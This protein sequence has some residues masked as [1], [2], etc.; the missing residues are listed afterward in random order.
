MKTK[1]TLINRR[2][3]FTLVEV[4][5]MIVIIA[6][7][8]LFYL[9]TVT[10]HSHVPARRINCMN[11]LKQIGTA[12]RLWA[13]DNG[14]VWPSQQTVASHGWADYLTNANLGPMCWTN[15]AIMAD[16]LGQ[17]PRLVLCSSDERQA[18][19]SFTNQ[20]NNLNVSYFVGVSAN[21]LYPQSIA[22]GDRNLG[23]G[24]ISPTI[25]ATPQRP[26]K[27][28]TSPSP[29]THRNTRCHGL[30]RCTRAE[31]LREP[32][33]SSSAT[34]AGNKSTPPVSTAYGSQMQ[35]PPPTGPP[36]IS[37]PPPP[38]AWFSHEY[39]T[40]IDKPQNRFHPRRGHRHDRHHSFAR[41]VLFAEFCQQKAPEVHTHQLHE[42]PQANRDRLSH[43]GQR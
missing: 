9:P 28:T 7:L 42:Q 43:M 18:A 16:D 21:D 29:P 5:V 11:N 14:D 37:P 30:L 12:Y 6:L 39:K 15:Y 36:A 13:N 33:I 17:E 20:F 40:D 19:S 27:G 41:L 25:S 32:A 2:T 23:S 35:T 1:P 26:G 34:A 3:A 8:A 38:S 22:A 31:I 4:I 24:L 10:T